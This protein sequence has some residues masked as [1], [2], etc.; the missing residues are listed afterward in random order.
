MFWKFVKDNT[1]LC[2]IARINISVF[3][4]IEREPTCS[5]RIK[6]YSR[7]LQFNCEWLQNDTYTGRARLMIENRT[8]YHYRTRWKRDNKNQ[9]FTK[10]RQIIADVN[11]E[12]LFFGNA[13][14]I[15]LW[16]VL[17]RDYNENL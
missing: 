10:K 15:Q 9:C 4:M 6:K 5:T 12:F 17:R 8:M 7:N 13:V 1:I 11:F 16:S 14:S 2:R 3:D